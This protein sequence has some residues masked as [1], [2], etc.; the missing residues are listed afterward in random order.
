MKVLDDADLFIGV[1]ALSRGA[2][3]ITGNRR[4]YARI[5]GLVVENWLRA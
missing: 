3:I 5:P 2:T 1:V 4:H